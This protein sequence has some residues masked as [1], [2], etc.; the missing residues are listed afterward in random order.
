MKYTLTLLFAMLLPAAAMAAR[1]VDIGNSGGTLTGS[2]SGLTVTDSTLIL[3]NNLYST[4]M[5]TGT[6]GTVAFSTA[7]LDSGSIQTGGTFAPGGSFTVTGNG[8]NGVPNGAIFTGS[9]TG[10]VTWQL[11]TLA[12][13][14]HNYNLTGIVT[15]TVYTEYKTYAASGVTF[16]L[17][18]NTGTGFFNGSVS[19]SSGNL[20][21]LCRPS[22]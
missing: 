3:V 2:A 14:S 7:A 4:G 12:D 16:Q 1:Q 11:I 17:T 5:I 18:V 20:N 10:E 13:G 6:L 15:G 22:Y 8:T 21:I 9:W 19:L